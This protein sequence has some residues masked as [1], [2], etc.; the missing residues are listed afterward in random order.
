LT[1]PRKG[2][3]L[4]AKRIIRYLKATKDIQLKLSSPGNQ[5]ELFGFTDANWA[6]DRHDRKSNSG[7]V[8]KLFGGTISWACRKQSC[9]ALSSTEAEYIALS[10]A[11]QEVIW[12]K[13]LC[14]EFNIDVSTGTKIFV[15]NQSAA[16]MSENQKFSNRT[17]HV[18]T[19]Y[20]FIRDLVEKNFVQLEY[21]C[22]ED[23]VAD[24]MTKPLGPTRI[25]YLRNL[26][27]L[28]N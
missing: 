9:I 28:V 21:V 16:K 27:E 15:D 19:K 2:D 24:L 20:H 26:I 12:L 18:D 25:S 5:Q 6:E 4:E 23:N 10:E 22:S 17:K 11:C 7:Y 8:F 13:K 1:Q 14:G 3:L